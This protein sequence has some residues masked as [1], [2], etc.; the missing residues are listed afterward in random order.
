MTIT[1]DGS[2]P[3]TDETRADPLVCTASFL[4]PSITGTLANQRVKNQIKKTT[5]IVTGTIRK[6][7]HPCK[8]RK[9]TLLHYNNTQVFQKKQKS[10]TQVKCTILYRPKRS[11]V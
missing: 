8:K 10:A 1:E 9:K 4:W 2:I 7:K 6:Q 5:A 11:H 3:C